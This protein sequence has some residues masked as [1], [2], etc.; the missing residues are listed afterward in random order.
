M[1]EPLR[2]NAGSTTWHKP[3]AWA[4]VAVALAAVAGWKSAQALRPGAPHLTL[5]Q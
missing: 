2:A 5:V 1:N 3:F 4:C